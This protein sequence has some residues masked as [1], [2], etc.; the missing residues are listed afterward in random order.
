MSSTLNTHGHMVRVVVRVQYLWTATGV[1]DIIICHCKGVGISNLD[2]T[3]ATTFRGQ[4]SLCQP[5]EGVM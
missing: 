1:V 2:E 3:T 4:F 5:E